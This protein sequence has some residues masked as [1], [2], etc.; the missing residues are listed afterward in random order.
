MQQSN[1]DKYA[2]DWWSENS[3]MKMLHSMHETR[4]LFI[5]ER[6]K[7][8][9]NNY[10]NL[11]AI[12]KNKRILDLGC[13]GGLLAE[14][15]C[16]KGANVKAIDSSS[17]LIK[18]AKKRAKAKGF[19][20]EYQNST[21]EDIIKK[22]NKFDIIISLEVIEHVKDYKQFLNNVFNSLNPKGLLILSTINRNFFSY[23][24]TILFSE[25]IL[26]LVPNGVHDWN[27]Y[28]KPEEILKEGKE[29]N[30]S[31]DKISG[32]CP[33]PTLKGFQWVRS[34]ASYANYIIAL[35]N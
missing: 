23:L 12:F 32:L 6:I 19:K 30:L 9:Y 31:L 29:N 3:S 28:V 5:L 16:K 18:V 35:K 27:Y 20:I 33:I 8:R 24:S 4:M 21:I 22:K 13:G 17:S 1:F 25:K 2:E 15:L 10:S 11:Q 34:R 26:K 7:N 14:S